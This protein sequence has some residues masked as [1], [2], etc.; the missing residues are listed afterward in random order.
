MCH[1]QWD[2][3]APCSGHKVSNGSLFASRVLAKVGWIYA[4]NMIEDQP[5]HPIAVGKISDGADEQEVTEFFNARR[6]QRSSFCR[7][8][9][10]VA[11]VPIHA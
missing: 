4:A 7:V 6:I 3:G 1:I 10:H 5:P 2:G 8:P 9:P 11:R